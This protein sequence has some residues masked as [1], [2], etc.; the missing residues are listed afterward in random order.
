M[1]YKINA[2][3]CVNCGACESECPAGAISEQADKRVIDA[4]TCVSCG[5]CS[6][7]CPTEAIAE[8]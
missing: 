1:A 5:A 8:E 3:V 6:G 7:V 4:A 2:D